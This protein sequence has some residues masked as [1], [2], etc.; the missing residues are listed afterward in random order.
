MVNCTYCLKKI[1]HKIIKCT[2]RRLVYDY[3]VI[4]KQKNIWLICSLFDPALF[5]TSVINII[6]KHSHNSFYFRT[7]CK[8]LTPS[9]SRKNI[10]PKNESTLELIH[11]FWE[12]FMIEAKSGIKN[13]MCFIVYC[14]S[15]FGSL[16]YCKQN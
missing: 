11:L 4:W 1:I 15:L 16:T 8:K 9:Q 3:V 6:S 14:S 7:S 5:L 12:S 13:D 10:N 2:K